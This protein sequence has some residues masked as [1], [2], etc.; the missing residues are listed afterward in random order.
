MR[1]VTYDIRGPIAAEAGR[2][3]AQGIPIIKLNT[4]NPAAFGFAPPANF[5]DILRENR[6][7]NAAYSDSKGL[8]PVREAIAAYENGIGIP[9]A[10]VER[11]FTGNGVSEL[12]SLS[13][14]AL[15]NE[16]DEVLI[17]SPDYPLW[18]AAVR[19]FAGKAVHYI[20]DERADWNPDLGA[21]R[22]LITPRTK[23]I[24]VISPN[25]PTGA[26]YPD[27]ILQGI[28]DIAREHN[29]LLLSDEIYDRVLMDGETHTPLAS[30]APDCP[31]ITY[32]GLSKSH[33]LCGYRCGWMVVSGQTSEMDDY[34]EG[35]NVLASMRL[36][37]NV[38]AQAVIPAALADPH[39]ARSH[40]EPGGRLYRQRE[41]AY[42]GVCSIPGLSAVK[43]RAAMYMF[44]KMD[45]KKLRIEDDE[46]FVLD[47]LREKHVLLTHGRGYH[48][49]APDH[50][51]LVYLPEPE[52]I[53][54]VMERLG[55]FLE[56]YRQF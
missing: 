50:F 3:E 40:L 28:C 17:P 53:A 54:D 43:P 48:W 37:S 2:M 27:E 19:L 41:I 20:C 11:V 47:F 55:D 34:L 1:N 44:P 31:V 13:M 16:G 9:G 14:Q 15:L 23:A 46:K 4:G 29:L 22:K 5:P 52:V 42:T 21:M 51:R 56:T 39:Y 32:N 45:I 7:L 26:V 24:V 38:P 25:N 30:L 10:D 35:L 12:I 36:C 33:Q 8:L 49:E 6:Q 18:T